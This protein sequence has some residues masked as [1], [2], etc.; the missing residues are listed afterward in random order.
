MTFPECSPCDRFEPLAHAAE[1]AIE[2][3]EERRHLLREFGVGHSVDVYE[4]DTTVPEPHDRERRGQRLLAKCRESSGT[5]RQLSISAFLRKE[6]SEFAAQSAD[7]EP[8]GGTPGTRE[9]P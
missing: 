5:S 6:F 8:D 1:I 2:R 7:H 3:R 9:L 4:C